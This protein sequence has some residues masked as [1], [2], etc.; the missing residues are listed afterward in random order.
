[1]RTIR[2][3]PLW[4]RLLACACVVLGVALAVGPTCSAQ[5]QEPGELKPLSD[6][7]GHHPGVEGSPHGN[8]TMRAK[9]PTPIALAAIRRRTVI[10][11]ASRATAQ[12]HHVQV[13]HHPELRIAPTMDFVSRED[14]VGIACSTC[15]WSKVT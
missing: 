3:I 8:T 11:P 10:P 12:L 4:L 2:E 1:M 9:A 15:P 6:Y 13:P 5:A 14:W 7:P